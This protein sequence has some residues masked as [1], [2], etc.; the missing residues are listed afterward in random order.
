MQGIHVQ[1]TTSK[2][3]N[4]LVHLTTAALIRHAGRALPRDFTPLKRHLAA[5][6]LSLRALAVVFMQ[7]ATMHW[8]VSTVTIM[9]SAIAYPEGVAYFAGVVALYCTA[10]CADAASGQAL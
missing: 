8:F 7:I 1:V 10:R 5:I 3:A 4:I 2:I 6:M 9:E